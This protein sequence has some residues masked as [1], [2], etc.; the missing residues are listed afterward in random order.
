MH[1]AARRVHAAGWWHLS[2]ISQ[3]G[4]T[5]RDLRTQPHTAELLPLLPMGSLLLVGN[6]DPPRF[7]EISL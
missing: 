6:C 7:A 2:A 5:L 1:V 3:T 4:E